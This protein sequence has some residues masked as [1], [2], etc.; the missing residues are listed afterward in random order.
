MMFG[1]FFFTIYENINQPENEQKECY[2]RK[3]VNFLLKATIRGLLV[4]SPKVLNIPRMRQ[5]FSLFCLKFVI[6]AI[7]RRALLNLVL[8]SRVWGFS[9][10]GGVFLELG[11]R[12]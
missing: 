7:P 5:G 12:A 3:T 9:L 2:Y 4:E 11:R 8:A 10:L 1:F 6:F